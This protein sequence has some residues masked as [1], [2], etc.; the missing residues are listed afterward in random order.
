MKLLN[1][2]IAT[3]LMSLAAHAADPSPAV[4]IE[5]VDV[6]G[7]VVTE[8]PKQPIDPNLAKEACCIQPEQTDFKT[9]FLRLIENSA[10]NSLTFAII[11]GQ[12]QPVEV[13]DRDHFNSEI[14]KGIKGTGVYQVRQNDL[15]P[16][17][18]K[19]LLK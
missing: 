3:C 17:A 10:A 12:P 16:N 4:V 2:M 6:N 1:L 8:A 15:S 13:C 14:Q 11:E 9:A 7:Q 19:C 18:L 5:V